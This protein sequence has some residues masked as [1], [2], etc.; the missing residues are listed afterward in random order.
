[1]LC[2]MTLVKWLEFRATAVMACD[3]EAPPS[4]KRLE[5]ADDTANLE[6]IHATVRHLLYVACTRARGRPLVTSGAYPPE[7]LEDLTDR[8]DDNGARESDWEEPHD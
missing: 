7:C 5:C 6:E 4:R 3:N 1:M 8:E 2:T